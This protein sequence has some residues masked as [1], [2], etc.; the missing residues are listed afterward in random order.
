MS[1]YHP[2]ASWTRIRILYFSPSRSPAMASQPRPFVWQ[3]IREAAHALGGATTNVAVR[4]W[5]LDRY[6]G[7]NTATIQA[8]IIVCTVNHFSRVHYPENQKPRRLP[9]RLPVPAGARP[10]GVVRPRPPRRLGDR[11]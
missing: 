8:Q 1:H 9:V 3:M 4:D 5:I 11:R 2:G 7:T 10:A 6:P